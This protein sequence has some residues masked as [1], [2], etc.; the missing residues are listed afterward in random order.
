MHLSKETTHPKQKVLSVF[1]L[2]MINVIAVDSLRNLAITAEYGFSVVF[3]YLIATIAFF[4]PIALVAAELATAWPHIGGLYVWVREAFGRRWGLVAIWLVWIYNI[5]WFP[6]ILAFL[7]ATFAYLVEPQL[8]THK[9]YML[10]WILGTFWAATLLN[11]FGMKISSWV[12]T[13]G[14]IVG[15]LVPLFF[16]IVLAIIWLL[17][18]H[19]AQVDFTFTD[20]IPKIHSVNDLAFFVAVL[21]S[22]L[23]IE[24]SAIHAEDVKNPQHDYPR[25]LTISSVII[26]SSLVCA[27]LAIA[28]VI[29]H[30]EISLVSGLI[31][32]FGAFFQRFHLEWMTPLVVGMIIIGGIA[33]VSA[34]IIG[35]TKGLLAAAE[36]GCLPTVFRYTSEKG[37]PI[38]L[39]LMQGLIFTALCAL[40]LFM[41][42]VNS[43]Y[44]V[45]S[46]LTAQLAMIAYLFMF[47]AAIRLRYSHSNTLRTYTI[48]GGKW[49]MWFTAGMGMLSCSVVIIIGF[50]PPPN[51]VITN[52]FTYEAILLGGIFI[53][54]GLPL[55][56][57]IHQE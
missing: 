27:S 18:G 24:M 48:P 37:A 50:F 9:T 11:C 49:G 51:I 46:A 52:L 19:E 2:V 40:F 23:G 30:D 55:L 16:I 33:S 7:A 12:S 39:L 47:S 36:D 35:P 31:D 26:V 44:W 53:F 3:F 15:T 32:A 13:I 14:A 8:S 54:V 17:Q 21:F 1:T 57:Y 43:F 25:A 34:W 41:P 10:F 56:L 45:L 6:T 29:P 22:L 38:A 20:F 5:V 28:I 42:T 4:I